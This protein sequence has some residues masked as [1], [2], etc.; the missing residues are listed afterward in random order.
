M[1]YLGSITVRFS[2]EEKII[3]S[4]YWIYSVKPNIG[5]P[6]TDEICISHSIDENIVQ[7]YV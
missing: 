1:H 4:N 7:G 3:I 2:C 6:I 5:D